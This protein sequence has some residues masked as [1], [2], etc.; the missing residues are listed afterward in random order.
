MLHSC[1]YDN[2]EDLYPDTNCDTTNVTYSNSV[3][4]VINTNCITCHNDAL[5][6]GNVSFSSYDK[7]AAVAN[8]GRLLGVI[9]HD[10]GFP[11]MP[12]G[13]DQ[14]PDCTI[15]KIEIWVKAGTPNN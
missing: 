2:V 4:P 7:I 11:A 3:L 12:Q 14:L 13:A 8:D 1:Y 6:N 9:R 10:N 5:A 15:K